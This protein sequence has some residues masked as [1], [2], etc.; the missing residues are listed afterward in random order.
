MDARIVQQRTEKHA[1]V[2]EREDAGPL[3]AIVIM[4]VVAA[5]VRGPNLFEL[6]YDLVSA[7]RQEPWKV[8]KAERI[9][10][11]QLLLRESRRSHCDFSF[12]VLGS[13][14]F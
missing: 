12:D 6:V 7:V 5:A 1:L 3:L 14:D 10:E 4:P 9:E 13:V 8:E 2:G 11:C